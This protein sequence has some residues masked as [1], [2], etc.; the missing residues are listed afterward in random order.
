MHPVAKPLVYIRALAAPAAVGPALGQVHPIEMLG[1]GAQASTTPAATDFTDHMR[2]DPGFVAPVPSC[3]SGS[4]VAV[5]PNVRRFWH[6]HLLEQAPVVS[7]AAVLIKKSPGHR[8]AQRPGRSATCFVP[9]V[10]GG[11]P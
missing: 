9:H 10:P 5:E 6:T 11:T 8:L 1:T 4:N 3:A 2:A 7:A